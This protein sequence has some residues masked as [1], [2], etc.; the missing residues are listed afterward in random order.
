[1]V[2]PGVL[3]L[4]NLKPFVLYAFSPGLNRQS[5]TKIGITSSRE[6]KVL[7]MAQ[8]QELFTQDQDF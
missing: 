5:I 1:L 6:Q 2:K 8:H 7:D 3:L 4:T